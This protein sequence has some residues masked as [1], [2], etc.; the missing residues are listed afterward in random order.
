MPTITARLADLA[1]SA[2]LNAAQVSAVSR[3]APDVVRV[4]LRADA[5]RSASWTP[6][7][8]LQLRPRRGTLQL[9]TYT[10]I[11]WD[12]DAGETELIA[13][14]HG[15]GPAADWFR[16]VADG[17]DC[18]VLGP[19][20]SIDLTAVTVPVVFVGDESSLGLACALQTVT[21]EVTHVFEATDPAALTTLLGD[22]G[23]A[24]NAT[25]VAK[26]TDRAELLTAARSGFDKP[27]G[28]KFEK[29]SD[30]TPGEPSEKSSDTAFG[31]AFD[32]VVT[33]DA[34]TVHAVRRDSRRWPNPPR[35]VH[36]KAYWAAGRTGLD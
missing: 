9:R 28:K 19:R 31:T 4:T 18:A 22:L 12:A 15:A 23:I 16:A 3:P 26:A 11:R 34:A 10:P 36:G 29:P 21:A 33:G 7:A 14:T 2:I 1:G 25:V 30:K 32:L 17:D 6:G 24:G 8:K 35:R 5:F 13:F 27:S 20:R